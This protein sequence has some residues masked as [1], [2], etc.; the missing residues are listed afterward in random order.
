MSLKGKVALVT[1]STGGIGLGIAR[2]LAAAGADIMLNGFGEPAAIEAV[3]AELRATGVR[4]EFDGSDLI[5]PT[6]PATLVH[7]ALARLGTVDIL[8]NNAGIQHTADHRRTSP[9][10]KWHRR[11]RPQPLRPL[12]LHAGRHPRH[13]VQNGWGRIINI[14]SAHGLVAS[15][16]QVRLRRRQARP[17]R[18]HQGRRHRT[19]QHRRHRQR[20]L[21]RLGPH[22]PGPGP[23]RPPA[24]PTAGRSSPTPSRRK[25]L[26]AEKQPMAPV[27][28]PREPR[29]PRR[30][31]LLR[32]RTAP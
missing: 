4:A 6:G 26:L 21:P 12:P 28:H 20:H 19:R 30:L 24:P 14:A 31:P 27:H 18:P 25:L 22:P 3:L 7:A 8:V 11:H 9:P 15:A 5:Q 17:G 10:E 29:R 32:S 1:G 23:D 2:A 16:Q 13:E